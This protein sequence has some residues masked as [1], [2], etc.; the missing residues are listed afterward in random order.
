M[1]KVI[2]I[3]RLTSDPKLLE[4]NDY[5]GVKIAL[6]LNYK[7]NVTYVDIMFWHDKIVDVI[8]KFCKKGKLVCV[9]GHIK[10]KAMANETIK[11]NA[12]EVIGDSIL[13]L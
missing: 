3:G 4:K 6:A 10:Q 5:R 2:L 7:D 1:N 13:L 11:I 12:Y 9:E 8:T